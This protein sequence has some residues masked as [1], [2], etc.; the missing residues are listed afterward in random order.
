MTQGSASVKM[1]QTLHLRFLHFMEVMPQQ[2]PKLLQY[3]SLQGWQEEGKKTPSILTKVKD[4]TLKK[5]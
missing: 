2:K 5:M 3:K 4:S 1:P